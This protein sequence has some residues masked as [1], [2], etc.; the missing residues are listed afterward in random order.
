MA[1]DYFGRTASTFHSAFDANSAIMSFTDIAGKKGEV[2]LLIQQ[3]AVNYQQQITRLYDITS[4]NVYYVAGRSQ[5]QGQLSQ[6]LGPTTLA[7]EFLKRY[8]QVC[9]ARDNNL[10]FELNSGNCGNISS[11]PNTPLK[12][13]ASYIVLTGVAIQ[14]ASQDMVIQQNLTMMVGSLDHVGTSALLGPTT[15]P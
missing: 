7:V 15:L 1:V 12:I 3:L 14:M 2:P 11:S 9:N 5:G 8:G 10:F 13:A 6:I 4:N